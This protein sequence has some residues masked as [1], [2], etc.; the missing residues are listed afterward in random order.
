MGL[1]GGGHGEGGGVGSESGLL[2]SVS[3][4]IITYSRIKRQ[5]ICKIPD[6]LF[7]LG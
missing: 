1:G 6:K 4:Y 2:N 3:F 5:K 7:Q